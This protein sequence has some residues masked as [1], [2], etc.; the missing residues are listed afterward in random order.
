MHIRTRP[1]R[2]NRAVLIFSKLFWKSIRNLPILLLCLSLQNE[3]TLVERISSAV[4][5]F[6]CLSDQYWWMPAFLVIDISKRWAFL[7]YVYCC[8]FLFVFKWAL[9]HFAL[10][11]V[12]KR[13][14][15]YSN[16][17]QL[18]PRERVFL[19]VENINYCELSMRLSAVGCWW[20]RAKNPSKTKYIHIWF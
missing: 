13:T 4:K 16:H 14:E 9:S 19:A 18:T 2:A 5:R 17:R 15:L 12:A 1:E 11:L 7:T 6:C 3:K 10:M 20:Q 8:F